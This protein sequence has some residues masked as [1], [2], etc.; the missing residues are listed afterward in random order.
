MSETFLLP[1]PTTGERKNSKRR[2][3]KWRQVEDHTANSFKNSIDTVEDIDNNY[4]IEFSIPSRLTVDGAENQK[5]EVDES[6][7]EESVRHIK[8]EVQFSKESLYSIES[9]LSDLVKD[10]ERSIAEIE[11]ELRA[12]SNECYNRNILIHPVTKVT[13][14]NKLAQQDTAAFDPG[15]NSEDALD[16]DCNSFWSFSIKQKDIRLYAFADYKFACRFGSLL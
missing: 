16:M 4:S 6:V 11:S 7:R 15:C 14:S 10:Y 3:K 5:P 2:K 13:P 1:V 9:S 12:E 8:K